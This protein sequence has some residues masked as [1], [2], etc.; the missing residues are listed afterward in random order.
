M[1]FTPHNY[2][3]GELIEAAPF[4]ELEAQVALNEQNIDTKLDVNNPTATGDLTVAGA[5]S[6]GDE[7]VVGNNES[8]PVK[9]TNQAI[10]DETGQTIITKLSA[11]KT[12]IENGIYGKDG[13]SPTITI[14]DITGGHRITIT[15]KMHPS[16]QN[17]DVLDG[18]TQ[19]ISGKMD[20]ANPVGTGTASFGG[21][22]TVTGTNA[23]ASGNG[24][25]ASGS[26]S[27]AE[28]NGTSASKTASHAEGGGT[29]ASGAYSHAEGASTHATGDNSH[30]EG[31]GTTASGQQSHAEGGGTQAS[32][33]N[34][35]AEGG[36]TQAIGIN[37]HAE[38]DG[39]IASKDGQ[40]VVG[41]CNI[42]DTTIT[43][44]E[45]VGGGTYETRKNI[46][47]LDTN[48]NE[49]I[50]GD[51]SINACGGANP[52]QVGTKLSSHDTS[53]STLNTSV[54]SL[55]QAI[56][57]LSGEIDDLPKDVQVN[58]TSVV[59][60]DGVANIPLTSGTQFGVVLTDNVS[61]GYG[62]GLFTDSTGRL[63]VNTAN[64]SQITGR[65]LRRNI[66]ASNLDIAVK[67]AMCDGIGASWTDA[68]K[69]SAR[70]RIG[71][72]Q[73]ET[74]EEVT[75]TESAT[76]ERTKDPQ[77]ND[78]NFKS[79]LVSV[80]IETGNTASHDISM[81]I[82]TSNMNVA[83]I[84]S[85]ATRFAY[86]DVQIIG[87]RTFVYSGEGSNQTGSNAIYRRPA[88]MFVSSQS[89]TGLQI[90]GSLPVGTQI[91]IY[92]IRN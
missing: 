23:F 5:G 61:G 3:T 67:S 4:N 39:T 7:V 15:D 66:D 80:W 36:S 8:V 85:S 60:E 34:S 30:S 63:Y 9:I 18:V 54:V 45:I 28:G 75:L 74:I 52:V 44:M 27:H 33:V 76:F 72:A 70:A 35:H 68:E 48:G 14:T 55:N 87:G 58:G 92:A 24:N 71:E 41:K 26:Y 91:K 90:T 37:S 47:T 42:A 29:T 56:G 69:K 51:L 89:I 20:K 2:R 43:H 17:I 59:D 50:A 79:L 86:A 49:E 77:G 1:S 11:I 57:T 62:T 46:R 16:G 12:A 88:P 32:G 6:F 10:L 13:V 40:H 25:T 83:Y 65:N 53:I 81:K 73:Y 64:Q 21:T 84:S 78:Y 38:G 22:N 19:D 82:G 31:G